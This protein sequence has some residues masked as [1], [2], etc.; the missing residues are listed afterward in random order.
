MYHRS[1]FVEPQ[2]GPYGEI[3]KG[4]TTCMDA[5]GEAQWGG[6]ERGRVGWDVGTNE[7]GKQRQTTVQRQRVV[8][9]AECT[10]EK[11]GSLVLGGDGKQGTHVF[12][13][14]FHRRTDLIAGSHLVG[15]SADGWVMIYDKGT[16]F[17]VGGCMDP[18]KPSHTAPVRAALCLLLGFASPVVAAKPTDLNSDEI[19]AGPNDSLKTGVV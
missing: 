14:Q 6:A 11:G 7:A 10:M 3:C 18:K 8:G 15:G 2:E 16:G 19:S 12:H 5:C 1:S 17:H 4:P 9:C 13:S